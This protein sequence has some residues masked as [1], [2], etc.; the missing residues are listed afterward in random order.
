MRGVPRVLVAHVVLHGAKLRAA[1]GEVV[2]A[3]MAQRVR[4]GRELSTDRSLPHDVLHGMA[5]ELIAA[6][7]D[8]QPWGIEFSASQVGADHAH[9]VASQRLV[10]RLSSL[11]AVNPNPRGFEIDLIDAQ[12][13][14]FDGS[15]GVLE[16]HRQ[17]Q[18]IAGA[19]ASVLG[20]GEQRIDLALYGGWWGLSWA[21]V[22]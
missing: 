15:Q 3:G 19:V 12:T 10:R 16:D 4:M 8:E 20:R 6:L 11:D 21:H 17:E 18:V 1:L 5:T 2:T 13:A 7:A 9:L 14:C 22:P